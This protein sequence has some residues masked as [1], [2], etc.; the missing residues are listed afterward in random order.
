MKKNILNK[1]NSFLLSLLVLLFFSSCED[2]NH[3]NRDPM[4]VGYVYVISKP[5]SVYQKH[6]ANN[7]SGEL[8]AT[9][10][11]GGTSSPESKIF[12]PRPTLKEFDLLAWVINFDEHTYLDWNQ[13]YSIAIY[14][15]YKKNNST[16]FTQEIIDNIVFTPS[17]HIPNKDNLFILRK[18]ELEIVINVYD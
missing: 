15:Q 7:E 1:K 6:L 8:F 4:R 3:I 10:D 9:L 13:S 16:E 17:D 5:D 18:G 14:H 2:N 11:I 12:R